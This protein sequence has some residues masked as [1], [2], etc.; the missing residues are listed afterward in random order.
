MIIKWAYSTS[1]IQCYAS[2][3]WKKEALLVVELIIFYFLWESPWFWDNLV[4]KKLIFDT[5]LNVWR[6]MYLGIISKS[7]FELKKNVGW[8]YCYKVLNFLY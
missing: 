1:N 5:T 6:Y 7:H 3:A 2:A 8:S 4:I